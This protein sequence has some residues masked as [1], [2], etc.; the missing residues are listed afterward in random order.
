[1]PKTPETA[2]PYEWDYDGSCAPGRPESSGWMETF[3]LGIFQWVPTK[4]GKRLKRGKVVKRIKGRSFNPEE[5][6]KRA[7]VAVDELNEKRI[8]K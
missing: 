3:S 7:Q 4:D 1:M 6:Y 8:T 5:C 2:R